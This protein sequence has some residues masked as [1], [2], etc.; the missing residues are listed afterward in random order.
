MKRRMNAGSG[1]GLALAA[2]LAAGCLFGGCRLFPGGGGGGAE[3]VRLRTNGEDGPEDVDAAAVFSWQ[4]ASKR[5]G[6]AQRAYRVRV[7]PAG[8]AGRPVWDSGVVED[9]RSTGIAYGGAPLRSAARYEWEVRVRDESGRWLD[10]RRAAFSTGLLRAGDWKGSEWIAPA[11]KKGAVDTA[12]FRRVFKNEK[13]VASAR[14]FVTGLGVFEAYVNGRPVARKLPGG[15][16]ERDVLKPGFTAVPKCRL[17][18]SYDVTGMMET[19]AGRENVFSAL[20]TQGWWRDQIT[21]KR[22]K[23]SAFR[24]ILLVRYADGTEARLGTDTG[25]S[26]AFAG[27][28]AEASIFGGETFDARTGTEWMRGGRP[29]PEWAPA[30]VSTEFSGEIRPPKGSR[31]RLRE[32]LE[33][34]PKSIYVFKGADKADDKH[35]GTVRI[36]R[37]YR[38]GDEM[39]LN[40]G[41]TLV[42]DL[43]QNAAGRPCI[44]FDGTPGTQVTV[45]HAEMLNDGNGAKNRRND[46]PEG[47]PYLRNLRRAFAGIRYTLAGKGRETYHPDFSF[48]GYRYLSLTTTAAVT[49]HKIRGQILTSIPREGETGTIKTSNP[50]V[51]RLISNI[52]WSQRSN[53]LSIPTDCPQRDERLGWT[54]DTQVFAKTAAYNAEV[55]GF[56]RKWMDDMRDSQ[57]EDGAFP[58]VAPVAQ[59]G[60]E[61][62]VTGWADAGII[63]PHTMYAMY[64]D[65][66]I[67]SE[68]YDAMRRYMALVDKHRG[69]CRQNYGDWLA[70][71]RNDMDIKMYLAACFY[72]WDAR[73]MGQI[74]R[75][76][77]KDADAAEYAAMEKKARDF[78]TRT[79]LNPD[80]TIAE[81]YRCQTASVYALHLGLA[82]NPAA[83]A[84][85]RKDLLDN[86][87]RH[88][89]K[90]QTG[91]LGTALLMDTL[92]RCGAADTAYTLLLQRGNP[93]WL[94]SVDQGATTVWERW[95]SYTI[96]TGFGNPWMNSFNHYAYGAVEAWMYGTMAGI[97]EDFDH[98]GFKRIRLEPVPD[99][100]IGSV[101]ASFRSP[102]GPVSAA[103]EYRDG[104][105][106]WSYRAEIPAN[107]E[108]S[109]VLPAGRILKVNGRPAEALTLERDGIRLVETRPGGETVFRMVSGAVEAEM[110]LP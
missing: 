19:G 104:G 41:E 103:W 108:A 106:A 43:G 73:M 99:K 82:P 76:L 80:G 105:K 3:T 66:T 79:Y 62:A 51:N 55:Y 84:A 2:G 69:P 89:G 45:R 15:R 95:N 11:G 107:T 70:Y 30:E 44:T 77:G 40:P 10:A 48:F 36:L 34:S 53:Y 97:R 72:V 87:A 35:F 7:F 56:L 49:V 64:G 110:T 94:Y 20:V 68:N 9:G 1:L 33:L 4:M 46:G 100:R 42:A 93:S 39:P 32:D 60:N 14:W 74:A 29:G 17:A 90:L 24:G 96:E 85:A 16:E 54:A 75:V 109:L 102:Y 83:A 101:S 58:S 88:G 27:P 22:G 28:V 67:L 6:A 61:G 65:K 23:G 26:A 63:V 92:T 50:L 38:D 59:Y 5:R 91:F 12:A 18:F 57:H 21:G 25:W 13:A 86:I 8:G 47:S 71:E 31:V 81:K 37:R 78:F 98:P 52:L